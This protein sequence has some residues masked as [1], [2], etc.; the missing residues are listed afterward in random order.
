M[1]KG[2]IGS[3][4]NVVK[5]QK[6]NELNILS[7]FRCSKCRTNLRPKFLIVL[8]LGGIIF[9]TWQILSSLWWIYSSAVHV[10]FYM[11]YTLLK[12]AVAIVIFSMLYYGRYWSWI[13]IQILVGLNC[14]HFMTRLLM[15]N[16]ILDD[17]IS[18]LIVC[19]IYFCLAASIFFYLYTKGVRAFCSVGHS[20]SHHEN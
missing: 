13:A 5:C 12:F 4:T 10:D 15:G 19:V 20:V 11:I 17:K 2:Q 9:G 6:C 18:S 3:S 8:I 14:L 1:A 7:F 16:L